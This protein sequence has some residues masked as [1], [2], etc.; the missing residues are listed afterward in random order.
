[1]KLDD[2][3]GGW[4]TIFAWRWFEL[5]TGAT[6]KFTLCFGDVSFHFFPDESLWG[7]EEEWYD[8]PWYSF[9]LGRFLLVTW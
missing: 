6:G 7:H 3:V 1:M 8:G 4:R 9:G 2:A 5:C